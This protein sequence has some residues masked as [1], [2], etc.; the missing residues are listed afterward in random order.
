[1][2]LSQRAALTLAALLTAASATAQPRDPGEIEPISRER[3][4]GMAEVGLGWLV[5]PGADV[6]VE[7]DIAGCAEGDSSLGLEAWQLFRPHPTFAVGAGITLGLTPT[8]DAPRQDPEGIERDH[9]RGYFAFEGIVRYYFL[10]DPSFEAWAGLTSGL[11]VVS[12]RFESTNEQSDKAL[13]GPRG[14]T[15]RTEGYTV[16][17]ALGGAYRFA[18]AWSMGLGIRYG[19]WFLPKEPAR[20][21]FGDEASL[22]GQ[23]DVFSVNAN[24]AYRLPL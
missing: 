13:V 21:P 3:L 19:S 11:V 24:I 10:T 22:V 23:N 9:S 7:R 16:G 6:C 20:G 14:V 17:L 18:P 5:L 8:S 4:M 1:M 12:D 15:I 2:A